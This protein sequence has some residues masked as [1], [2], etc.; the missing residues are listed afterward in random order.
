MK[1]KYL[2]HDCAYTADK[3]AEWWDSQS[4]KSE[5][6]E[7]RNPKKRGWLVVFDESAQDIEVGV[8]KDIFD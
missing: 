3:S 4:M 1:R 2:C 5:C 8:P 6:D 7:C